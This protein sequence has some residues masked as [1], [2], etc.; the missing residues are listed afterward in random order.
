MTWLALALA[1]GAALPSAGVPP[2]P[3]A[4]VLLA[5]GAGPIPPFLR[6]GA[7]P[8]SRPGRPPRSRPGEFPRPGRPRFPLRLRWL[9]LAALAGLGHGTVASRLQ[10]DDCRWQRPAGEVEVVGWVREVEGEGRVVLVGG[11]AQCR[12]AL[13]LQGAALTAALE[14]RGEGTGLRVHGRWAPRTLPARGVD[15][16]R[17]GVV[18][19]GHVEHAGAAERGL[20][21]RLARV[22]ARGVARIHARFHREGALVAALLLA[23]RDGLDRELRDAFAD[24]GTAHLLAISGFHVGVFAGLVIWI[25]RRWLPLGRAV[26]CGTG[27]SWL[28][29]AVLGFPDAATRAVTLLT[30][31]SI[32]RGMNRPVAAAGAI[33]TALLLM[34]LVDPAVASRIGAQLSFGGALGLAAWARP[35]TRRVVA[36]WTARRGAPPGPRTRALVDAVVVNGVA[37]LATLPLIAWHFERVSLVSVPASLIATPLGAL[38]VPPILLALALDGLPIPGAAALAATGAEGLLG[39]LRLIVDLMARV[40]GA[41]RPFTRPETAAAAVGALLGGAILRHHR[42]VGAG[43]RAMVLT[44]TLAAGWLAGPS[45]SLLTRN[46]ALEVHLFDVGQGDAIGLRTPGG[47]WVLIDTGPPTGAR[48]AADLRRLGAREVEL[49]V[50]SHPDADHVGGAAH[51]IEHF[52]VRSVAGPGTIRGAGPWHDAVRAA[53][54]R[55]VPWRVVAAGDAFALDG[56]RVRVH[57][58]PR[59]PGRPSDANAASLVLE[60]EWRGVGILLTGDAPLE[61]ERLVAPRT[62][63]IEILKVGHHGSTT[64]TGASLLDALAPSLA[65]ISAGRANRYGHPAPEVLARLD[66][67][68]VEV[69]R[70][71]LS[72]RVTVRIDRAGRWRVEARR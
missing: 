8:R 27:V 65:L 67:R 48:L 21:P 18:L 58:P 70:T 66:E 5:A 35:T 33:G 60:V 61:A 29:L 38:S 2:L 31:I 69:W 55:G 40:P 54:A 42:R 20:R 26:L 9:P 15:P 46:G 4:L 51:L 23:R 28:Y 71:D 68:G 72:G 41:A 43:A 57:H 22:R 30:L 63:P 37:T 10:L 19:V 39:A 49:L 52:T 13:R 17:A 11:D 3:A 36:R 32:G 12:G 50:V 44:A 25:A 64:S 16:L 53:R 47:R 7:G 14:G 59:G 6:P 1:V 24:T 45:V 34:V 62:G 56:V